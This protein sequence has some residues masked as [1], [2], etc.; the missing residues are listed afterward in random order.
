MSQR[1]GALQSKM[2]VARFGTA[3]TARPGI[4]SEVEPTLTVSTP[5]SASNRRDYAHQ[6][7]LSNL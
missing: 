7:I 2:R 4:V 5:A 3:S 1:S 6:L